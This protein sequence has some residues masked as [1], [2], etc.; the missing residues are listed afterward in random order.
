MLCV[1]VWVHVCE[2]DP[3]QYSDRAAFLAATGATAEPAWPNLGR[4]PGDAAATYHLGRVTIGV[5]APSGGLWIGSGGYPSVGPDWTTL[6]AGN[7]LAIDG[8]E[9]LNVVFDTPMTAF[10]FDFAEP[11]AATV[12]YAPCSPAC[13]CAN[14]TFRVT[15]LRLGTVVGMFDFSRPDNTAAF[16]GM[17]SAA[18]F[19]RAEVREMNG[20]C[21]DEYFGQFW[22]G[23]CT[24][25]SI[26]PG[27]QPVSRATCPTG[28][29]SFAVGPAGG[30]PISYQWQWHPLGELQW[31][32]VVA[33]TN[34]AGT[35][36]FRSVGG[37]SSEVDVSDYREGGVTS[38]GR[39]IGAHFRCVLT[40]PCGSAVSDA[41]VL[42][43]CPL[44]YNCEGIVN[45]DDLG[46]FITDYFTEPHP[47][48][49]GGYAVACPDNDPPYDAGYRAAYTSDGSGQCTPPFPD[50]LGDYITDY[51]GSGC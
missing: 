6:V 20:T 40:G 29:V 48:G 8:P 9:N 1:H 38:G 27:S 36:F 12:Q 15:L 5:A 35:A 46:D 39:T 32:D 50:N 24:P 7:D 47:F 45:P 43:V 34:N 26:P 51:F 17:F 25:P 19:D 3:V 42:T 33:G 22:A 31:Q 49:P 28:T 11:T 21:D 13:P 44:D 4:L 16:V 2:A 10:G 37:L 14:S 23:D 41:A 30:G 18:P